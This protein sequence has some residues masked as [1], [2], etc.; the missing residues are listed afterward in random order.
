MRVIIPAPAAPTLDVDWRNNT[1]FASCSTDKLIHVCKLGEH[2]A[3]KTFTGHTDEVN[4][5]RWDPS[6]RWLASCSD[7]R[8]A[9]VGGL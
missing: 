7:D 6:G 1:S 3:V 4:A 2:G 9:K 5:I 8:T